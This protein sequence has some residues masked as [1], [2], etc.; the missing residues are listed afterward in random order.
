M[1]VSSAG[2]GRI[3]KFA[4]PAGFDAA[5]RLVRNEDMS[6]A[7]AWGPYVQPDLDKLAA[8][9][10]AGYGK[11]ALVQVGDDQDGFCDWFTQVLKPAAAQL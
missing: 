6:Q 4:V 2:Y 1:R 3:A 7:G 9:R 11:V 10:D 8:Y 5:S